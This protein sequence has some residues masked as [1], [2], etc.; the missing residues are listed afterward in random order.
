MVR[1]WT[2]RLLL[3]CA[4]VWAA[5]VAVLGVR[6]GYADPV[7]VLV[8]ALALVGSAA[9]VVGDV[10]HERRGGGRARTTTSR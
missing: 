6:D 1:R 10:L 3:A 7:L 5:S 9:L 4:V 2:G 8:A